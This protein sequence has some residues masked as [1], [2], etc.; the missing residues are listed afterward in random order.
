MSPE[1]SPEAFTSCRRT[2][3]DRH[4]RLGRHA[5][6]VGVGCRDVGQPVVLGGRRGRVVV[7]VS[8]PP[9]VSPPPIIRPS[10][11]SATATPAWKASPRSRSRCAQNDMGEFGRAPSPCESG[12]ANSASVATTAGSGT[13]A[14]YGALIGSRQRRRRLNDRTPSPR[15]SECSAG[16][17][18]GQ[19][20]RVAAQPPPPSAETYASGG[21]RV[22]FGRLRWARRRED[23]AARQSRSAAVA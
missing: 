10:R 16:G 14:S 5:E 19:L 7:I 2:S 3:Q 4:L 23:G 15:A 9:S 20:L 13:P 18:R 12:N 11:S 6:D 17:Q 1:A 22:H 21:I 8:T